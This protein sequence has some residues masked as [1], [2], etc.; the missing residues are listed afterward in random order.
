MIDRGSNTNKK[1]RGKGNRKGKAKLKLQDIMTNLFDVVKDEEVHER[2]KDFVQ[3]QRSE[4]KMMIGNI[5]LKVTKKNEKLLQ[6]A[7]R[8]ESRMLEEA[9]RRERWEKEKEEGK[10]R[11]GSLKCKPKF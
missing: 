10:N 4:R 5:D 9:K 1:G 2:E 8:A 7:V 3:D 11:Q 6:T